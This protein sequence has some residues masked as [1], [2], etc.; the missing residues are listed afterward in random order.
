MKN[1]TKVVIKK[2]NLFLSIMKINA[3][4]IID[5]AMVLLTKFNELT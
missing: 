3:K 4:S 1:A 5:T 2:L